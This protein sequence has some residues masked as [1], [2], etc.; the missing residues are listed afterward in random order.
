VSGIATEQLESRVRERKVDHP[1]GA[2][3]IAAQLRPPG[4]LS[5]ANGTPEELR[6]LVVLRVINSFTA[7][8]LL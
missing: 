8:V 5:P 7:P 1:F 4:Q 6:R 2:G 3:L